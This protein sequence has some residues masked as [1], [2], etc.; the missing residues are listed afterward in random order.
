[1][2]FHQVYQFSIRRGDFLGYTL[3]N[4]ILI[5]ADKYDCME[6]IACWTNQFLSHLVI[7]V[8]EHRQDFDL[9]LAEYKLD[10]HVAFQKI[11][12]MFVFDPKGTCGSRTMHPMTFHLDS[13]QRSNFP[14][15]L[16]GE[17]S[18]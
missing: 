14:D 8:D 17:R 1:M 18:F 16:V 13:E 2:T 15:G 6:V 4:N 10:N 11:T 7:R 5:L 3:L 9:L 12:K